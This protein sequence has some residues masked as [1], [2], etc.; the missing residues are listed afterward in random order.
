[1]IEEEFETQVDDEA[2][3]SQFI[4]NRSLRRS[5]D[6]ALEADDA[7]TED[8]DKAGAVLRGGNLVRRR[9]SMWEHRRNSVKAPSWKSTSPSL[10]TNEQVCDWIEQMGSP[11]SGYKP[12][13]ATNNTTGEQLLS[14][15]E[16][17]LREYAINNPL[18][19]LE[20]YRRIRALKTST[21]SGKQASTCN[22]M[23]VAIIITHILAVEP[24]MGPAAPPESV[25]PAKS[26]EKRFIAIADFPG[27]AGGKLAFT[28]YSQFVLV[29]EITR[30][31]FQMRAVDDGRT[32]LVPTNYIKPY[33]PSE[34]ELLLESDRPRT[35]ST[36]L[37][38]PPK[39]K[40]VASAGTMERAR[41]LS[42][43]GAQSMIVVADF[44]GV[45][46]KLSLKKGE[47]VT[48]VARKTA[49]WYEVSTSDGRKGYAP[50][51]FLRD[52]STSKVM[53]RAVADYNG[54]GNRRSGELKD[55]LTF[56]R[57][58]FRTNSG[59]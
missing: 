16:S 52:A 3:K 19:R 34:E 53:F 13:F 35:A 1:M 38:V 45:P 27:A 51:N 12:L 6:M 28:A 44:F 58:R 29:K 9:S 24:D 48:L 21:I 55:K 36:S 56:H 46:P 18:H 43:G 11:F 23:S 42:T 26:D 22:L 41:S 59:P 2:E 57:G 4:H 20:L 25:A 14:F 54:T 50:A 40:H 5:R 47:E 37:G 32:G 8:T 15:K 33:T 17:D 7:D 49:D 10:W 30:D 39:P 31:W